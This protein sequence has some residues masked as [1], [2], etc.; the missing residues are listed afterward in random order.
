MWKLQPDMITGNEAWI[1]SGG[2]HHS[3]LS[4]DLTAE[5]MKDF[6]NIMGIEC[7]HIDEHTT[8]EQLRQHL[9]L[10]DIIWGR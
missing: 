9:S 10:S 2:A 8:L 6:A 1:Y 7:I 4:Y 5:H 3:V